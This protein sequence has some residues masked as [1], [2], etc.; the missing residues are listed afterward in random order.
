MITATISTYN[1]ENYLPQV[2]ESLRKQTLDR[3]LF[4]I[5]LVNNNSPGETEQ[6]SKTFANNNPDVK[7]TYVLETQQGL[8]YGRNRG[9]AEAKGEFITF[10]DD[11]AFLTEDYLEKI[12][13]CFRSNEEI[14]AIGS[15]ILLHYEAIVPNWENKYLNSLLG[16]F[17]LGDERKKF[18]KSDYPRGSNMSFRTSVFDRVGGFN[19][20]LGRKGGN[21]AG[22]EEKDLF[23]RIYEH[24]DL[25]VLYIPDAVVMHCVPLERT[26][27]DF[28]KKQALGTGI[29]EGVRVRQEG[30]I[31][32]FKRYWSE[33]IKW[34][35]SIYLFFYFLIKK[36]SAK[37]KMIL[38]F[39]FFVS[40]GLFLN[41]E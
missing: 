14:A 28:I 8:S 33:L 37:G 11:D 12:Y 39:R 32:A 13:N 20:D 25:E 7:F 27:K 16:Y 1:R 38:I 29:S 22:S 24:S 17:N 5:V 23:Q 19:V 36:Q 10:I 2:L 6:I 9:I 3:N 4:E 35:G 21:L 30:S 26:T 40:K 15:K 31:V 18:P 34:G 41:N